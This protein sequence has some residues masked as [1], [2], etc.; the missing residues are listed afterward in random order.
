MDTALNVKKYG[1]RKKI[2]NTS[3]VDSDP[4]VDPDPVGS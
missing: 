2:P 3:V 4:V 1:I